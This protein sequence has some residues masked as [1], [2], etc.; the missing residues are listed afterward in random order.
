M[1]QNKYLPAQRT[2]R[3]LWRG[4][5]AL[6]ASS[7]PG[8]GLVAAQAGLCFLNGDRPRRG[9]R[10]EGG[11][12]HKGPAGSNAQGSPPRPTAGS[13]PGRALQLYFLWLSGALLIIYFFSLCF[14]F[15]FK[16][17]AGLDAV[18]SPRCL[19]ARRADGGSRPE[20]SPT[21]SPAA[22]GSRGGPS[23]GAGIGGGGSTRWGGGG[24]KASQSRAGCGRGCAPRWGAGRR[25][26]GR[27]GKMGGRGAEAVPGCAPPGW[28]NGSSA[29]LGVHLSR[30]FK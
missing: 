6:K 15:I 24:G 9:C 7:G 22:A 30:E 10:G 13:K 17:P 16:L 14:I 20:L 5:V 25:R 8:R 11:A 21:A 19:G 4:W 2:R 3:S 27:W 26:W 12:V 23:G 29:R 18:H 28:G 1:N